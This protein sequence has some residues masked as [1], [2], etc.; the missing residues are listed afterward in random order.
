[1]L[2]AIN[3]NNTNTVFAVWDGDRLRG[4]WRAATD[5]RR[6]ADEYV[7]WLDHLLTL[8]GLRRQQLK[9]TIIA[10]VVPEANFN[11]RRLCRHYCGSEPLMVGDPGVALGAR[12][13]IDRPEEVG[14]D[15]LCNTVGAHDRH[16]TPLVVVDFGTTTNFDVVDAA[17]NYCGG[18]IAPG[19]NLSNQALHLAAA[20]LPSVPIRRPERVIGTSTVACMQS[21]IFWGY[22]GLIEGLVGR[23]K[24]EFGMPMG[25]I[26]TGGLA[27]LFEGATAAIDCIDPDLTLWGLRL[28][29][30]RNKT[31]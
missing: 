9:G 23:V 8:E 6:T 4:A 19:I 2:L 22:V 21:G 7:V 5:A 27:P 18:I 10:S 14:A 26:A 17:G 25:V 16:A 1:M 20:K 11:L 12:A 31:R 3:A 29:Y 15:R 30:G 28:I 13:I 24:E